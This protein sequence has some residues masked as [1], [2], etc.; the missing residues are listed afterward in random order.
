MRI[1]ILIDL[2]IEFETHFTKF[3]MPTIRGQ[4]SVKGQKS[5][6]T[7]KR[8]AGVVNGNLLFKGLKFIF[9]KT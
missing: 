2:E 9:C 3:L 4:E 8:Y 6:G 7:K 1:L 5:I